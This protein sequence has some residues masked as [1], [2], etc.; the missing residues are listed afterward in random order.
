MVIKKIIKKFTG[1][2]TSW[3]DGDSP[4]I[5]KTGAL[6]AK[7]HRA[8]NVYAKEKSSYGGKKAMKVAKKILPKGTKVKVEVV[9]SSYGRPVSKITKIGSKKPIN[10]KLNDA[11]KKSNTRGGRGVK[12][13]K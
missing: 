2:V 7:E 11:H 1:K 13:K 5:K 10:K 12:K 3:K 6:K 9:G 4:R 8:A